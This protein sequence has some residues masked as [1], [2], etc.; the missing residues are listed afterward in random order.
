MIQIRELS[1]LRDLHHQVGIGD[2]SHVL[3]DSDGHGVDE[4]G[5]ANHIC[6][7]CK[8]KVI[9]ELIIYIHGKSKVIVEFGFLV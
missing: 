7:Y 5:D 8:S 3:E 6:I 9:L 2:L 4:K 1:A